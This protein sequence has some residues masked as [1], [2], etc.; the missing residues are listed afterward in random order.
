MHALLTYSLVED[1]LNCD[2]C[3]DE[4]GKGARKHLL[5]KASLIWSKEILMEP[6]TQY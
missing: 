3:N 2:E 1:L 5:G 4:R 6:L